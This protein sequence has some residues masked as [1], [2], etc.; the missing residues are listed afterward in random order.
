[1]MSQFKVV[2]L[3][4][5]NDLYEKQRLL[6]A[7]AWPEFIRHDDASDEYWMRLIKNFED[8][9]LLLIDNDEILS[10]IT[11]VPL[12]MEGELSSLPE[13]GWDWVV[14]KSVED[15][16]K[17]LEP[18]LLAGI[19]IV[20]NPEHQGKGISY[21]AVSEMAAFAKKKG[22]SQ[23]VIPVRPSLKFRYPLIPIDDYLNWRDEKGFSMD[24]WIRVHEKLGAKILHVCT[25]AMSITGTVDEWEKWTGKK[26]PMSGKYVIEK[27]LVPLEVDIKKNQGCYLEPNVWVA[28]QIA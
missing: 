11:T 2:S 26:I 23:L 8:Y 13:E 6:T 27:G 25:R 19:Q 21:T 14:R 16:E 18:T 28:H 17:N 4:E 10:I 12:H 22:F 1:M 15:Y 3:S 5:R 20:I 7:E 9:Q 24:P